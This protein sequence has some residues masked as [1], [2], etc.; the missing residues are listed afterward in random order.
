[1]DLSNPSSVSITVQKYIVLKKEISEN[2]KNDP[3]VHSSYL[4]STN[5]IQ[6]TG[7]VMTKYLPKG[8]QELWKTCM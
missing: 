2:I 6:A 8:V 4:N 5:A 1:M 3:Y 7:N